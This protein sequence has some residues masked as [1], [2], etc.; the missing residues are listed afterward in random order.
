MRTTNPIIRGLICLVFIGGMLPVTLVSPSRAAT[1]DEIVAMQDAG[2]SAE[3]IIEVIQST[4]LD[5][6]LDIDALIYLAQNGVDDAVL[7]FLA[8]ALPVEASWEEIE[9]GMTDSES[10]LSDHPNW[11]GGEGFHHGGTSYNPLRDRKPDVYWEG[12][13][14]GGYP[15][16][17]FPDYRVRVYEPPVYILDDNPYRAYRV[18]R[19]YRYNRPYWSDNGYVIY[20]SNNFVPYSFTSPTYVGYPWSYGYYG[21]HHGWPGWHN[22]YDGGWGGFRGDL[23][24]GRHRGWD[25]SFNIWWH[26]DDISLRFR[27]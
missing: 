5:D 13:Q 19:Y 14:Y 24:W 18:P 21:D 8:Q 15:Y 10:D 3:V 1:L 4:G 11:A 17:Y 16:G 12:S 22:Y 25:S 2:I 27:F 7:D 26:D 6:P 23:S 20:D 9:A